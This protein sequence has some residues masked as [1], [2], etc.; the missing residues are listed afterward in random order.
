MFTAL[1]MCMTFPQL[2]TSSIGGVSWAMRTYLFVLGGSGKRAKLTLVPPAS[3]PITAAFGLRDKIAAAG[4]HLTHRLQHLG[5]AESLS[6][7]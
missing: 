7:V 5:K 3:P 2:L 1:T 6:I 4:R